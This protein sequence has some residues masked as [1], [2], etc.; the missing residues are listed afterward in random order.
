MQNWKRHIVEGNK[1]FDSHQWGKAENLYQRAKSEAKCQLLSW[2]DTEEAVA[3]LV[4]S[5]HNLADLY[6]TS[7][8]SLRKHQELQ[9][10]HTYLLGVLQD[11]AL[12]TQQMDAVLQGIN[13]T[14]LALITYLQERKSELSIQH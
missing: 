2:P 12:N 10:A 13:K 9:A 1:H 14:Y 8:V 6:G 11:D 4:V 7:D 5:Y 3:A